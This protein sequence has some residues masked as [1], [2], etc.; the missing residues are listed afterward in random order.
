MSLVDS[1]KG[2]AVQK[3]Y[4]GKEDLAISHYCSMN[5]VKY[6]R[7]SNPKDIP[8]GFTPCGSVEWCLQVL[9]HEITPDYYPDFLKEHIHRKIWETDKWP[10]GEK[11]FIKPSK[12]YKRFTGFITSG[13]YRGKKKGPYWCSSIVHFENEWRYYVSQGK[14][15]TGE[16]YSGD[17]INC[18]D[19]P[20]IDHIEFPEGFC[21]AV[22][23]G[24]SD[25]KL[26]L[27]EVN[28]P[29]ACGWYGKQHEL[30]AEWL[31]YGWEYVLKNCIITS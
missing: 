4:Q 11:V 15:L 2:F 27:V 30:Y 12:K 23:L 5:R 22:D 25:G 29:F 10:L 7:V 16:W 17:D 6:R 20:S 3:E 26:C 9:G 8:E 18:P 21:G 1:I 13:C 19:A 28:H 14:V 24:M 31:Y